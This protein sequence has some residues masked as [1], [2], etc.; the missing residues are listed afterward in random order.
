MYVSVY[1]TCIINL[2]LYAVFSCT[3]SCVYIYLVR[4]EC[5]KGFTWVSSFFIHK[6]L[7][8]IDYYLGYGSI[9]VFTLTHVYF[10]FFILWIYRYVFGVGEK[11]VKHILNTFQA[12]LLKGWSLQV[13]KFNGNPINKANCFETVVFWYE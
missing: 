1:S 10:I 12:I 11:K 6:E 9:R 2:I 7:S 3:H 5:L 13:V 4:Y 8:K